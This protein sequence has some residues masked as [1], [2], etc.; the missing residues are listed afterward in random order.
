MKKVVI[1]GIVIALF[2]GV[3]YLMLQSGTIDCKVCINF[4]GRDQCAH[5]TGHD[6]SSALQEAHR[7]ACSVVAGGVT[8]TLECD[9]L[10]A[11]ST[12]CSP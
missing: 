6:E 7:S 11:E 10:P 3:T 1:V 8:E 4:K 2:A 5:A 12:T 9:R